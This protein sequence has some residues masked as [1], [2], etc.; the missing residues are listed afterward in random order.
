MRMFIYNILFSLKIVFSNKL[1]TYLLSRIITRSGRN[2]QFLAFILLCTCFK[3]VFIN[4]Y[5][6]IDKGMNEWISK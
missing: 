1:F 5:K 2:V 3:K 4:K 6:Y